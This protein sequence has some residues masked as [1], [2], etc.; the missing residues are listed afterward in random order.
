MTALAHAIQPHMQRITEAADQALQTVETCR[1]KKDG[2][3]WSAAIN[4]EAAGDASARSL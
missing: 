1:V 2:E 3:Q 4:Q